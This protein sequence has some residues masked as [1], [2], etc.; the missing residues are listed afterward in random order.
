[1]RLQP[2]VL[3]D[4]QGTR[5]QIGESVRAAGFPDVT[6][7]HVSLFR[8]P[9]LDRTRPSQLAQELQ[10]SK[11]AINDLLRDLER[12]GYLTREIDANDRRSRLT[13]SPQAGNNSSARSNMP[14]DK[15]TPTSRA[16]SATHGSGA[17]R[18][19]DQG[20]HVGQTRRH[21]DPDSGHRAGAPSA[22]L[23]DGLQRGDWSGSSV[24]VYPCM[25]MFAN[26]SA[27]PEAREVGQAGIRDGG[28]CDR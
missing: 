11:Q 20:G 8:Y 17:P 27:T 22:K 18:R 19:L 4:V 23:A 6:Q 28:H 7:A 24:A 12:R 2:E 5:D 26:S 3:R 1:V 25:P 14:Q 9:G 15:P 16:A 13:G 10:I 21:L